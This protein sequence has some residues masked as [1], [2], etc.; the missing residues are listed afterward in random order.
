MKALCLSFLLLTAQHAFGDPGTSHIIKAK[1]NFQGKEHVGYFKVWGY[2][3]LTNDSLTYDVSKF[4]RQVKSW[5]YGDT[6]EFYS[7]II[8]LK[9][10]DL[11]LFPVDKCMRVNK[12]QVKEIHPLELIEYNRWNSS[13][14]PV[15]STDKEWILN[16]VQ[17]EGE[18]I[19]E[20]DELCTYSVLYF[21]E[22]DSISKELVKALESDIRKGFASGRDNYTTFTQ[23][24]E[25]LRKL[26][27][28][29]FIH[30]SPS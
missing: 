4:T 11:T 17:A 15:Q 10:W 27:V 28:M 12:N 1:I 13:Y 8:L 6:I 29:I 26:K 25:Q 30:C 22:P 5:V 7:E 20:A 3:Y 21:K 2:L 23:L 9:D 18:M 19:V 24:I 16:R 14:T